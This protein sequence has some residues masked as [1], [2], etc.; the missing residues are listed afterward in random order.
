MLQYLIMKHFKKTTRWE[1]MTCKNS[2]ISTKKGYQETKYQNLSYDIYHA[3][4]M[5]STIQ[6]IDHRLICANVHHDIIKLSS[7]HKP[8]YNLRSNL[9]YVSGQSDHVTLSPISL[10]P[11]MK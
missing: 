7:P 2:I 3:R 8:Y 5:S 6:I 1:I 4:N 11:D 10:N 9:F